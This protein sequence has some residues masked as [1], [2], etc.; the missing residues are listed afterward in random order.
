MTFIVRVLAMPSDAMITA[1]IARTSKSPKTRT[2]ASSMAPWT[3]SRVTTSKAESAA[4]A[5]IDA[6]CSGVMSGV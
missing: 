3:S 1:T 4:V 2:S 5:R 6:C